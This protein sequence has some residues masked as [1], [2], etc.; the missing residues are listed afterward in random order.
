MFEWDAGNTDHIAEHDIT[1]S[2]AEEAIRDPR[3]VPAD[4]YDQG[5]EQRFAVTGSTQLGRLITVVYT[6]RG[7]R[8]DQRIR[9]VTA[10]PARTAERRKY[11]GR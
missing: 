11:E 2:E 7:V 6:Y 10:R 8:R 4:A 3:R 1:P 9:V 5:D